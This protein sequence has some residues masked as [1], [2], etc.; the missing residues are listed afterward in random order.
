MPANQPA[1]PQEIIEIYTP[2]RS[3]LVYDLERDFIFPSNDVIYNSNKSDRLDNQTVLGF[4][5]SEYY[6]DNSSSDIEI[7]L[8]AIRRECVREGLNLSE[9]SIRN[10]KSVLNELEDF[11]IFCVSVDYSMEGGICIRYELGGQLV[12]YIETYNDG[13]LGVLATSGLAMEVVLNKDFG[14]ISELSGMV[15]YL[16]KNEISSRA[17]FGF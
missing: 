2:I 1:P 4:V 12:V 10:A 9:I 8:Q 7:K 6:F 13:T 17:K 16:L 15:E 3:N 5:L 11:S 14:T